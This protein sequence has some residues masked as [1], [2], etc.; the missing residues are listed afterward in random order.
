MTNYSSSRALIFGAGL[1]MVIGAATPAL[2]QRNRG[3]DHDRRNDRRPVVVARQAPVYVSRQVITPRIVASRPFYAP[4]V[5]RSISPVVVVGRPATRI[6]NPRVVIGAAPVRFYSP[7]YQFRPR[8]RIGSGFS[9]GFPV[10]YSSGYYYNPYYSSGYSSPYPVYPTYPAYSYPDPGV[11]YPTYS[12]PPQAYPQSPYA[13]PYAQPAP[14]S[15]TVQPGQANTG[16]ASFEVTPNTAEVLVDGMS[17]GPASQFNPVSAPL[18]LTPG[19]H[20]FEIRAPGYRTIAFD[21]DIV[22]G[23][24]IPFQGTM[25]R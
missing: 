1:A 22:A 4:P 7:Y 19:H 11:S 18:G 6:I 8:V 13:S 25:E 10:A 17:M 21:S 14:G 20:H 15:V 16:G 12:Y 24:V 3:D 2:A 5:Y 9:I 23:Q